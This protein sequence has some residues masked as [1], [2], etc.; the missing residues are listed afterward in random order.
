[1]WVAILGVAIMLSLIIIS[2]LP[3]VK[4]QTTEWTKTYGG[5]G[6]DEGYSLVQTSDG[7]YAIA[8]DTNSF[9]A[10][11][12]DFYLVKT[13]S[14]GTMQWNNTYGGTGNEIGYSVIQTSDGGYAIAGET[15][16]H[17]AGG[18]D[19][20]LVKTDSAG[21]MQWNKTYGGTGDDEGYSLVQTSDGGY[22]I[23]GET[24][25]FGAGSDDFY[26]VKT[27]SAGNMQWNKTYGG[28][29]DDEGY[30]L[31]Q[32]SDGGYA[33]AGITNSFGAGS[34]DVY[35]VK[36]DS[37]GNM[38]WNKT[39]G[40]TG[41]DE[42]YSLVQTSDGGYAIAGETNSYGAG[43]YDFYLVKTDSAGTMQWNQTYGGPDNEDG[44]SLVQTSDGGYAMT[45]DTN[46]FGAGG[47]DF[48]LVKT[49]STGTMQWNN[50][51]G[52]KDNEYA[53][54]GLIQTSDGGYAMTG[55]TNSFGA[56][57]YDVYLV[58]TTIPN[59]T[60]SPSPSSTPTPAPTPT[61]N[62]TPTPT[63][64]RNPT[65]APT[66]TGNPTPA[67]TITQSTTPSVMSTP[68]P[69]I[70]EF[71]AQLIG[72][73]LVISLIIILSAVITANTRKTYVKSG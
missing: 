8:G 37:A 10:G 39:Y 28:T 52:G 53:T 50:T 27:D 19:V 12:Y 41:D 30:S 45:G 42:G 66:P 63:P 24:N 48:Y 71:P 23:A 26:L 51:Y 70:P 59:S 21:N 15:N 58:K 16:S 64:T 56:G 72:I 67:P 22:A 49:D 65:P 54:F 68:T 44:T 17:G 4:G 2:S 18:Y 43:D 29:G 61:Q 1:M 73:T 46:S 6:N 34:Y 40:G 13:D 36:T 20:Y 7:G 32:T 11:G 25:S 57:G 3:P 69:T 55:D 9:G 31:V 33:I 14:T 47:Y 60:S 5:K 62:P 38:Q 35:L